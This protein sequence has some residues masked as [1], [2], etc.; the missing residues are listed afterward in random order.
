LLKSLLPVFGAFLLVFGIYQFFWV[1]PNQKI[2][3]VK[4]AADKTE[5]SQKEFYELQNS[6][7]QTFIQ[8]LGGAALLLGLYFTAKTLRT[9]Q[10]GQITDRFTKA[11]EQLGNK[12]HLTVRLGGIYALERIA[13]DSS[14]DH[15]QI[16]EVLMA[17]I[18]DNALWPQE[19]SQPLAEGQLLEEKHS[20][21]KDQPSSSPKGPP[22]KPA[23]DIQAV[24]TVLGRRIQSSDRGWLDLAEDW[25]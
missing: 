14:K 10:E 4:I 17:Y 18:R 3:N 23:T 8:A 15:W 22:P 12:K 2:E 1:I 7:R 16:M 9:T 11:I 19:D 13:R 21:Q 6:I 20:E 25:S 5:L 24:L